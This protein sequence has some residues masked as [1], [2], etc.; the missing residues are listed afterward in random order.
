[1][2]FE[3]WEDV[4]KETFKNAKKNFMLSKLKELINEFPESPKEITQKL[5]DHC[6]N[7]T[8]PSREYMEQNPTSILVD[9]YELYPGKMD[10]ATCV[11]VKIGRYLNYKKDFKK[12]KELSIVGLISNLVNLDL[13]K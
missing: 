11:S 7:V 12:D 9:N 4:E 1:M 8:Q 10:H 3:K 2:S 5:I 6:M 13:T